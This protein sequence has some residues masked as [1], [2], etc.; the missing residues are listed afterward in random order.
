MASFFV[1]VVFTFYLCCP[2]SDGQTDCWHYYDKPID[3]CFSVNSSRTGLTSY[4]YHCSLNLTTNENYVTLQTFNGTDDCSSYK[5]NET[6]VYNLTA[7]DINTNNTI[8]PFV[9]C[10]GTKS[11]PYFHGR[12]YLTKIFTD[13]PTFDPTPS[14]TIDPTPKPSN[15]PTEI[16]G[17]LYPSPDPTLAPSF[18]PTI[19][20]TQ[21]PLIN[22]SAL[23]YTFNPTITPTKSPIDYFPYLQNETCAK[24]ENN[25]YYQDIL[26]VIDICIPYIYNKTNVSNANNGADSMYNKN[27]TSIINKYNGTAYISRKCNKDKFGTPLSISSSLFLSLVFFY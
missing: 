11:C 8:N 14:P 3:V 19:N 23:N 9:S 22:I 26:Y 27:I 21:S 13:S 2:L 24:S 10:R 5:I 4:K 20:P 7:Y 16:N 6:L 12:Y 17:T 18:N 1:L 25:D 15:N